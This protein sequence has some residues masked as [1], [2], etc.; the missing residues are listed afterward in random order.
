MEEIG[1]KEMIDLVDP[2]YYNNLRF[3]GGGL[4]VFK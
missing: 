3:L 4:E 2:I 1:V